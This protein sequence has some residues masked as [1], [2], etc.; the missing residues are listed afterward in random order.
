MLMHTANRDICY[1]S[2]PF[3]NNM[4]TKIKK[5]NALVVHYYYINRITLAIVGR[6]YSVSEAS[7]VLT[8]CNRQRVIAHR[9]VSKSKSLDR[10]L[11][12]LKTVKLHIP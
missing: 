10:T 12:K 7:R 11:E 1:L 8:N 4:P 6:S 2:M 9:P 3:R 5:S